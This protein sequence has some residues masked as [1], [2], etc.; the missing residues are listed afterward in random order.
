MQMMLTLIMESIRIDPIVSTLVACHQTYHI[1]TSK[2]RFV[3]TIELIVLASTSFHQ[4]NKHKGP[5][6]Y[7]TTT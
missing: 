5:F 7:A 6:L 2:I 3:R 1:E 4:S